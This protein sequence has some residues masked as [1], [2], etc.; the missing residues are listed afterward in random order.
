MS[1]EILSRD[2][3][4]RAQEEKEILAQSLDKECSLIKEN[5][6]AQIDLFSSKISNQT[7]LEIS[8]QKEKILGVYKS[9]S[10]NLVLN[11]KSELFDSVREE[12]FSYFFNLDQKE[13]EFLFK[14]LIKKASSL[15][16][17]ETIFVN[18]ED[19]DLVS[20]LTK[21]KVDSKKN[22]SG[23]LFENKDQTQ[24]LDLSFNSLINE[25]CD[26]ESDKIQE[27]LFK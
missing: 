10:K 25:I 16:D 5:S 27:V 2:V 17:F 9:L 3:L 14:I 15:I 12:T 11:S 13:K 24:I 20:S 1:L 23:L 21:K 8:K 7:K 4:L 26:K 6:Q 18:K 19:V 22:F